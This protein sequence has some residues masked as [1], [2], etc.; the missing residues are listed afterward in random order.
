MRSLAIFG[1]FVMVGCDA[2]SRPKLGADSEKDGAEYSSADA[3]ICKRFMY[4]TGEEPGQAAVAGEPVNASVAIG[5]CGVAGST[6]EDGGMAEWE[7]LAAQ[8]TSKEITLV[9]N[10]NR[11]SGNIVIDDDKVK[12]KTAAE[13]LVIGSVSSMDEDTIIEFKESAKPNLMVQGEAFDLSKHSKESEGMAIE[14]ELT[15]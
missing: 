11:E 12:F 10:G 1:L 6:E 2:A 3:S 5:I 14:I 9:H 4:L 8:L 7:A 15:D 13:S